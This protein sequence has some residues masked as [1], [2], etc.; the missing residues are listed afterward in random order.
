[1]RFLSVVERELRVAARR[2]GTFRSRMIAA[3]I[4]LL[5]GGGMWALIQTSMGGAASQGK[6]VFTYLSWLAFIYCLV[7]GART[8]ADSLSMEKRE[9]TLG[10]LFLTDLRGYD[11]V[12]GKLAANSLNAFFTVMAIMPMLSLSLLMGGVTGGEFWRAFL[13]LLCALSLSSSIGVWISSRSRREHRALAAAAVVIGLISFAPLYL[14]DLLGWNQTTSGTWVFSLLSPWFGFGHASDA[15]YFAHARQFWISLASTLILSGAFLIVASLTLGG[16]WRDS[17]RK[18]STLKRVARHFFRGNRAQQIEFRRRHLTINPIF[19]IAAR[20]RVLWHWFIGAVALLFVMIIYHMSQSGD[21]DA[22]FGVFT[23][24]SWSFAFI[25]KVLMCWLACKAFVEARENGALELWLCTPLQVD[26]ILDGQRL[27]LRRVWLAALYLMAIVSVAFLAISLLDSKAANAGGWD[28]FNE[29]HAPMVLAGGATFV[30]DMIAL[31][32]AGMWFGLTSRGVTQ[33]ITR[34]YVLVIIVP[35]LA[36]SIVWTLL[37]SLGMP[38]FLS[39]VFGFRL[40]YGGRAVLFLFKNLLFFY[41]ARKNLKTRL[42]L[43]ASEGVKK[44]KKSKTAP[45]VLA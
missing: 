33:A 11:V 7:E 23:M 36:I 16:K 38:L 19:W 10:L 22:A 39:G 21:T 13:A 29:F 43:A 40:Y 18:E 31:T 12:A 3:I 2:K 34:T 26:Q 27:A 25:M 5:I 4:S 37:M 28:Q 30:A 9:G 44:A 35:W 6:L 20:G 17:D 1:M 14:D 45:P 15:L 24:F 8:T 42:R 41:W 32:W